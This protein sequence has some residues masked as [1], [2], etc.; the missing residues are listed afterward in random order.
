[1]SGGAWA[2]IEGAVHQEGAMHQMTLDYKENSWLFSSVTSS[3]AI[4]LVEN[5][6][7]GGS[8][9]ILTYTKL[10]PPLYLKS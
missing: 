1:M 2:N 8:W 4:R 10:C 6:R 9:P 3:W 7:A 5:Y